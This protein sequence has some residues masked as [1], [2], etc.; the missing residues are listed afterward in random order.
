M[1]EK[2]HIYYFDWLRV[3]AMFGVIAIHSVGF[4]YDLEIG[5]EWGF[6]NLVLSFVYTSVPLFLM[7]SGYLTLTDERTTDVPSLIKKRI[8]KIL[9]P[10]IGWTL[11]S[12]AV[13]CLL[14]HKLNFSGIVEGIRDSLA[15]PAWTHLWYLYT[16]LAILIISPILYGGIKSLNRAGHI[17]VIVIVAAVSLRTMLRTVL[18]TSVDA[19]LNIDVVNKLEFFSG[20]LCT[21]VLGYYLGTMKKKI[22]NWV[23]VLVLVVTLGVI[24]GGPYISYW[25]NGVPNRE[26]YIQASGFE[27]VLA[28]S[29]FLLFKQNVSKPSRILSKIPIVPL[30]FGVY[31]CHDI[32]LAFIRMYMDMYSF[33]GSIIWIIVTFVISYILIK[34]VATIKPICYIATGMS[35]KQACDSCN[36]VYTFRRIKSAIKKEKQ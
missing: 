32:I 18:P 20:H 22:P 6:V 21:F 34:T 25:K 29:V 15:S 10:L 35:Y 36:W 8:P 30:S 31:L 27:I 4:V 23:L 9:M 24:F 12:I 11:V 3:I 7:M 33:V 19:W 26:F 5:V 14:S 2:K 13:N 1:S 28:T 17:L 16:L